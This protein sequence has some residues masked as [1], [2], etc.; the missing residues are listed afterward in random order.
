MILVVGST[1]ML[2]S[3]ICR[4]LAARG[5][6]VRALVRSGSAPTMVAALHSYGTETVV[7]DL[8]DRA[9][10]EAACAGIDTVVT[11]ASAMPFSYVAGDND[12]Q[13]VDLDGST[14]LV[15][16]AARAG[17]SHIIYTSFSA[18]FEQPNELRDAKRAV[19]ATLRGSGVPYTI[20]HPSAFME[21]WLSPIVGFDYP[22]ATATI[23]GEGTAPVSYIARADVAE[24]AVQSALDPAARNRVLELGGPEPISQLG[25]V[26]I[27]ERVSGRTFDVINVPV[28]ALRVQFATATDKM[29]KAFAG[30]MLGVAEGDRI[31]MSGLLSWIPLELTS[32]TEYAERVLGKVAA[33]A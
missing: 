24:F 13:A 5:E 14:R 33:G 18:N 9:S 30:L 28:D 22:N 32:V 26:A 27:F 20:L 31:D 4:R 1:G 16:V 15:D 19:E 2:G 7:G 29:A 17:V 23:Y 11:T 12:I 3:E 25:A 21:A 6:H 10:L 8:R